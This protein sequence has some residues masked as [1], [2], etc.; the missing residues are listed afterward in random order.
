MGSVCGI[1]QKEEITAV[2]QGC[3]AHTA[4]IPSKLQTLRTIKII[5]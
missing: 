4:A 1:E 2:T 3:S 5:T